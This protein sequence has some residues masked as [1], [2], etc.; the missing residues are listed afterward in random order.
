MT[1]SATTP[2]TEP[3]AGKTTGLAPFAL[4]LFGLAVGLSVAEVG[5]RLSAKRRPEDYQ[6]RIHAALHWDENGVRRFTPNACGYHKGF[7]RPPVFVC[8][9]SLGFRGPELRDAPGKRIVFIGDSVVF[10]GGVEFE[11][12]FLEVVERRLHDEGLDV[13]IVNAGTSD[14]GIEQ[15]ERQIEMGRFDNLRAHTIVIGLYLNDARPPQGFENEKRDPLLPLFDLPVVGH[16]ALV[17]LLRQ[18]YV[19]YLAARGEL[20]ERFKWVDEFKAKEWKQDPARMRELVHQARFDWGAAWEPS[21][22]ETVGTAV[23][24][25]HERCEAMGM[26]LA[27]ALFPASPQAEASF[28]DPYLDEPQRWMTRFAAEQGIPVIDLLPAL[29]AHASDGLFADQCHLNAAGNR[30]AADALLTFVRE[31]A[32]APV[33]GTTARSVAPASPDSAASRYRRS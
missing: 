10:N 32:S 17:Q 13:E 9:N 26:H 23:V 28:S 2:G 29:Q 5:I 7:G 33:A 19:A 21:F 4:V 16:S 27:L 22:A 12:T 14:V 18:R 8:V 31:L 20:G 11:E 3:S 6:P 25:M 24:R 1:L 15:Y 30:V